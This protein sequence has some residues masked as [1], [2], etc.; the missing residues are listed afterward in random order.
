MLFFRALVSF[1]FMAVRVTADGLTKDADQNGYGDDHDDH[2]NKQRDYRDGHEILPSR[3]RI[4]AA[5]LYS[6]GKLYTT[7]SAFHNRSGAKH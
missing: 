3:E 5:G 4:E 6:S 1:V 7:K 2:E